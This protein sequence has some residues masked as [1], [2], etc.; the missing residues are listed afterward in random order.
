M[1]VAMLLKAHWQKE[2]VVREVVPQAGRTLSRRSLG[3]WSK[4]QILSPEMQIFI[5]SPDNHVQDT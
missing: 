3:L 5:Q 2:L 4:L 1:P